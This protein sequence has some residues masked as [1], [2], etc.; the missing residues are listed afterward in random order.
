MSK[1]PEW[2]AE[3][4][5]K[6]INLLTEAIK[7]ERGLEIAD[8]HGVNNPYTREVQRC[9]K[10][11]ELIENFFEFDIYCHNGG[12]V[13]IKD[14]YIV[15]LRNRTYRIKGKGEWYTYRKAQSLYDIMNEKKAA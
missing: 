11:I 6:L 8:P 5:F 1:K 15:S 9:R 7:N 2:R 3:H 12:T 13:I 14:K 10:M 4:Y